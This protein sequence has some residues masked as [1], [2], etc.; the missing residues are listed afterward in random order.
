M[1]ADYT[2]SGQWLSFYSPHR[3]KDRKE[4]IQW[5]CY[6]LCDLCVFAVNLIVQFMPM[7]SIVKPKYFKG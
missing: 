1:K 3:R 7:Y 4:N 2:L 6:L 5:S